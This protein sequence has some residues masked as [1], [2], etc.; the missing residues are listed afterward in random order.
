MSIEQAR[1]SIFCLNF[2]TLSTIFELF[3]NFRKI[4]KF[5]KFSK[6]FQNVLFCKYCILNIIF[7]FLR[8]SNKND[9][10]LT[11]LLKGVIA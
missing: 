6:S 1:R 8:A 3:H 10:A 9:I 4:P 11:M 2:P 5:M 7:K